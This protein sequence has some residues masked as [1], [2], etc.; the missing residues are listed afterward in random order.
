MNKD[1]ELNLFTQLGRMEEKLNTLD[2]LNK[3][4]RVNTRFR[5]FA[6]AFIICTVGIVS[7]LYQSSNLLA[8][9]KTKTT[10]TKVIQ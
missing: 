4:V 6:T 1:Q 8:K 3:S 9:V 5:W 2:V 10:I 7:F